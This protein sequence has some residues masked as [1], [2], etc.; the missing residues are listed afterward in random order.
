MTIDLTDTTTGQI[1]QALT[2]ARHRLGGRINGVV[3][4]LV[5][6]TD[7]ALQYDAIRAAGQAAREH[8][9]LVLGVIRR[10]GRARARLDAEIRVGESGPGETVLLRI[11]GPLGEHADS[12]V[13]PLLAP[14]TPVV[15]WWPGNPPSFP[16]ADPLGTLA[17][18]RVT[19]VAMVPDPTRALAGLA[20]HYEPGDTDFSWTRATPWRSLL[21]A[22]LDQPHGKVNGGVV[23]AEEGNASAALIAAWLSVKLNA[24]FTVQP[25]PGPGVTEVRILLADSEITITRPDGRV[26]T[27]ARPGQP[28]RMVALHRR[29]TADLLAEELRRLDPDEVYMESAAYFARNAG[30]HAAGGHGIDGHSVGEHT[31]GG[32]SVGEHTVGGQ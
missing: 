31:A 1:H 20:T 11:Y 22:T 4:S 13:A 7:E 9:C 6:G 18:R 8:P 28:D 32:H 26:A 21:A 27:L 30:E 29:E 2:Q 17:R 16:A 5:I 3:L 25:S 10:D 12:V 14:D 15:T 23:A 24:S 19:D